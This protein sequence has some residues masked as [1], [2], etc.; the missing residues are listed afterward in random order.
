[1]ISISIT[2]SFAPGPNVKTLVDHCEQVAVL[3]GG[4]DPLLIRQLLVD[5]SLRGV[6]AGADANAHL[7][8]VRKRPEQLHTY[9]KTFTNKE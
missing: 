3:K 7:P 1:M 5:R 2:D 4:G 9:C 6:G 8:P